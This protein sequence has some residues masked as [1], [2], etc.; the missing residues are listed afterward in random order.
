MGLADLPGVANEP[1]RVGMTG[2]SE[3]EEASLLASSFASRRPTWSGG[4]TTP[5]AER[6]PETWRPGALT[7]IKIVH[8]AA[9][10]MIG[11]SILLFAW[12]GLRG[13]PRRRTA[14][15]ASVALTESAIYA[16]NNQVCPLTP[17]AEALGAESGTVTDI[18]LPLWLSRRIPLISSGVLVVGVV[19]NGRAL[20][21]VE[22]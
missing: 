9:F 20:R 19:L 7:A 4:L 14:I 15:A 2:R 21:R 5:V 12:D 10:L 17:L 3:Q 13:R 8:T 1:L 16:S 22:R 11:A 6:V 18:F